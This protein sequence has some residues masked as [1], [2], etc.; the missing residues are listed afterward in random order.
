MKK[1]IFIENLQTFIQEGTCAF[2][3]V[4]SIKKRLQEY[5]FEEMREYKN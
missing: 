4:D 1:E 5:N 2:T 3:C